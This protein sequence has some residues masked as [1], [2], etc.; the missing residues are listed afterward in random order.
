MLRFRTRSKTGRVLAVLLLAASAAAA[1]T[2]AEAAEA[3]DR[4][5]KHFERAE[6][7]LAARAFA[8]ADQLVPER[9]AL[10]NAIAA[11]RKAGTHLL[12]AE[13]AERAERRAASDPELAAQ[14]RAAL[15]EASLKLARLELA[16]AP[17]PCVIVLDDE[18]VD[19]GTR[20]VLPGIHALRSTAEGG[21]RTQERMQLA[22]GATYRIVLHPVAAG[23]D[24][25]PAQISSGSARETRATVPDRASQRPLSPTPFWIGAGATVALAGVTAWSGFDALAAKRDLPANPTTAESDSV[26]SRV[27]RT[28]LLLAGS[29][30]VGGLTAY[31]GFSL[32]DWGGG[33]ASAQVTPTSGG[34]FASALVRF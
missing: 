23:T 18:R 19:A 13:L 7:E 33:S 5:V 1:Q 15:A 14:A 22:A 21:A 4:G 12:V 27:L 3:F 2:S 28:D 17:E 24:R 29:V 25:I 9:N 16:C 6:Y 8:R 10:K 31:A 30:L 34:A 32:V 26:R 20:Y 11:A